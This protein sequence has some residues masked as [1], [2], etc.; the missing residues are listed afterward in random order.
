MHGQLADMESNA[1]QDRLRVQQLHNESQ[2]SMRELAR[3]EDAV[4]N[5]RAQI[6]SSVRDEFETQTTLA[7]KSAELSEA[8]AAADAEIS[9]LHGEVEAV[10]SQA[11]ALEGELLKQ[12]LVV[13]GAKMGLEDASVALREAEEGAAEASARRE[14]VEDALSRCEDAIYAAEAGLYKCCVV[15]YKNFLLAAY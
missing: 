7:A 12:V 5:Y 6:E 15:F 14:E 2:A 10:S 11:A 8:K 4:A 3:L 13:N 9:R 1:K